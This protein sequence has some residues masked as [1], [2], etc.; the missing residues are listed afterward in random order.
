[1]L[2][3]SHRSHL[4]SL[5]AAV[6]GSSRPRQGIRSSRPRVSTYRLIAT[7]AEAASRPNRDE[8]K[9]R[10]NAAFSAGHF[11]EAAGHFGDAITLAP[12]NHILFSNRSVAYASLGHYK[13]VLVDADRTVALSPDWAKGYSRL[14][15]ARLGLDD[16]AGAVEAY[17]KGL[18]LEPSNVA[19]KDGLTQ[20]RWALSRRPASGA[21]AIGSIFQSPDLWSKI[22]ADPTTP[23]YLDQP[24]FMQMLRDMQRNPDNLNNYLSDPRMLQVFSLML[25]VKVQ[26]QNN[27]ASEPKSP[28]PAPSK[29][30]PPPP[31][32]Q[33]KQPEGK[34]IEGA[35]ARTGGVVFNF[36]GGNNSKINWRNAAELF[37]ILKGSR[38]D[39]RRLV[40][41]L[42]SSPLNSVETEVA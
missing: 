18:T 10:G 25:N 40:M 6:I 3:A 29:S 30:S 21:D 36:G 38:V 26:N 11:E 41:S 1:M 14:G 4:G 16:A 24:D 5:G 9:A 20:A 7:Q 19:L 8:A 37:R 23:A 13:E 31:H 34:P 22:A 28:A 27:E 17:E 15:A 32:Q 35:G 33:Q 39:G 42:Q 2:G 12:D